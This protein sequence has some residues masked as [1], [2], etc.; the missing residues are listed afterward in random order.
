MLCFPKERL[1][2]T[3][4]DVFP[5]TVGGAEPGGEAPFGC[6][7]QG[8]RGPGG[9]ARGTPSLLSFGCPTFVEVSS[10]GPI[11]V[12][13][14]ALGM[15][16]TGECVDSGAGVRVGVEADAALGAD[17]APLAG[18]EC[19]AEQVG[20]DCQA[21]VAPLVALRA[22]TSLGQPDR[23]TAAAGAA[24]PSGGFPACGHDPPRSVSNAADSQRCDGLPG[25]EK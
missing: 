22:D 20:P 1:T 24:R 17:T 15:D 3:G 11:P 10:P 2:L 9:S 14:A 6:W 25:R 8:R 12:A 18:E 21:V 19:A 16:E 7:V 5:S 4:G 13:A 23:G